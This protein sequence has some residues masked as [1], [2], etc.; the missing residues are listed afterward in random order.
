MYLEGFDI[1]DEWKYIQ[2][3]G[4]TYKEFEEKY[5]RGGAKKNE[6]YR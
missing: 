2:I 4:M 1:F 3:L 6:M 5:L